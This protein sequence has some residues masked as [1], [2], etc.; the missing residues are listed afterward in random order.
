ML[1][2]VKSV[3]DVDFLKVSSNNFIA[4]ASL[5]VITKLPFGRLYSYAYLLAASQTS[6]MCFFL[7]YLLQ[8]FSDQMDNDIS[9]SEL[10]GVQR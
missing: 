2:F 3:N 7:V 5:F 6:R 1:A 10:R 9:N 8:R 4:D